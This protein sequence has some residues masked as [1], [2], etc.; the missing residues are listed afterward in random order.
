MQLNGHPAEVLRCLQLM[1]ASCRKNQAAINAA[2]PMKAK[3]GRPP[4]YASG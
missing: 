3:A 1:A 4:K 2:S